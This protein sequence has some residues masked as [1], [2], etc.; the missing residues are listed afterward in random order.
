MRPYT[1]VQDIFPNIPSE[2][3]LYWNGPTQGQRKNSCVGPIPVLGLI[4]DGIREGY[5]LNGSLRP[6]SN[7]VNKGDNGVYHKGLYTASN[8]L[9]RRKINQIIKAK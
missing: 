2:N 5:I 1:T 9:M 8:T 3:P 4:S 7:N 6:P